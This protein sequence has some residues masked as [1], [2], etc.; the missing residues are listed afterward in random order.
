MKKS[1]IHEQKRRKFSSRRI[2]KEK[3]YL[4]KRKERK[5][6]VFW[7]KC[8]VYVK[9]KRKSVNERK[10]KLC[11]WVPIIIREG[12]WRDKNHEIKKCY[13][14]VNDKKKKLPSDYF[15]IK[16]ISNLGITKI[17][18]NRWVKKKKFNEVFRK[19]FN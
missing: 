4:R 6:I 8:K 13:K 12:K 7:C 2:I 1:N 17:K 10:K 9:I 15:L 14:V 16:L 18:I 19:L 5:K 3:K 11:K